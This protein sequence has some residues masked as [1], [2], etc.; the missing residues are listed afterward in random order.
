LSEHEVLTTEDKTYLDLDIVMHKLSGLN[1]NMQDHYHMMA[2]YITHYL[3]MLHYD[4]I[5]MMIPM[6]SW[7]KT[8]SYNVDAMVWI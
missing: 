5:I 2:L 3:Y 7:L 8:R 1:E 4:D 6:I